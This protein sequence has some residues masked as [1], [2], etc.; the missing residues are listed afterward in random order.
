MFVIELIITSHSKVVF[1]FMLYKINVWGIKGIVTY[2]K[3]TKDRHCKKKNRQNCTI[4]VHI[5]L[6]RKLIL[7]NANA[8]DEKECF[9]NNICSD[10]LLWF[11]LPNVVLD[12]TLCLRMWFSW[13]FPLYWCTCRME[14]T[15]NTTSN[16]I[17]SFI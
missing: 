7:H 6:R 11:Y 17:K 10:R 12:F 4:I 9:G 15:S 2:R 14:V 3:S 5:T 1:H 8:T 13:I 16:Q